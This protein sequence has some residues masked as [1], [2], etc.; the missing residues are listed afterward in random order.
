ME[1]KLLAMTGTSL[2]VAAF[3]RIEEPVKLFVHF[4]PMLVFVGLQRPWCETDDSLQSIAEVQ[5]CISSF[6]TFKCRGS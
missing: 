5:V 1:A 3:I 2:L 4:V 6:H